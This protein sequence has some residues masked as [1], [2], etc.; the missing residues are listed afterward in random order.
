MGEGERM[1]AAR[2]LEYDIS[3]FDAIE[4]GQ[5]AEYSRTVTEH[6]IIRFAEIT[7]DNNPVHTDESYAKNSIFKGRI[8]HGFLSA[9]FISTV[10]A[11]KL[12]GPGTI[13]LKQD[14]D[15]KRPVRIGDE[16]TAQVEV[17]AKEDKSKKIT[18]RTICFNQKNTVVVD[19]QALV[20]LP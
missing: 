11:S 8:A 19:G 5:K 16:I 7:G 13:Y 1:E 10:L 14:L 15:F 20:A 2:R 12:P 6:D 17:V 3:P 18:L 9:S 4:V